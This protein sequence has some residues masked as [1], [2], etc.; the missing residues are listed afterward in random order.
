MSYMKYLR[1]IFVLSVLAS[2]SNNDEKQANLI[3][4]KSLI[5]E[6]SM[7]EINPMNVQDA[8]TKYKKNIEQL[9]SNINLEIN[10]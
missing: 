4:S 9:D 2:C 1:F 5:L 10:E 6:K 3:L 8:F 7:N